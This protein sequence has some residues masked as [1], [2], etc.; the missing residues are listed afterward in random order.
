[1]TM[2][3]FVGSKFPSRGGVAKIQRIVDGVVFKKHILKI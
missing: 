1:M 2:T 3:Q